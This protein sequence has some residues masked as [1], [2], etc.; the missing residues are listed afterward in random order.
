AAGR[1]GIAPLAARTVA[2]TADADELAAPLERGQA[3]AFAVLGVDGRRVGVFSAIGMV[4]QG[5]PGSPKVAVGSYAGGSA[6]SRPAPAGTPPPEDPACVAATGGCGLAVA[7]ISTGGAFQPLEAPDVR[8]GGACVSGDAVIV[9]IDGDGTPEVFPLA[10]FLDAGRAP[11]DELSAAAAVPAPC[12]PTYTHYGIAVA[13]DAADTD[14]RHRVTIDLLGVLDLDADGRM[15]LVLGL[16]Y[17]ERRT[18]AVYSAQESAARLS[19]IG[20][21]E[22]WPKS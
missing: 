7:T 10:G 9:D 2:W 21:S 16:R 11:A 20:E 4:E 22:P 12:T 17:S 8:L 6:C 3:G 18:I 13:L 1:P 5:P 14:P 19:L 15:E